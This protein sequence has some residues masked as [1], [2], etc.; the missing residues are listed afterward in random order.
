M[1]ANHLQRIAILVP[2]DRLAKLRKV[3]FCVEH[4][5]SP[6]GPRPTSIATTSIPLS[7]RS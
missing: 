2:E 4:S 6:K 7:V 1:L 3:E 5:T